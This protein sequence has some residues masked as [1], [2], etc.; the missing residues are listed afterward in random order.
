M[1]PTFHNVNLIIIIIIIIMII[2]KYKDLTIEIQ[3][4]WNLKTKVIPV[5]TGATGTISKSFRKYVSNIPGNHEVKE[6]QKTAILGT[7]HILRKML[8]E[9]YNGVNAGTSN[10]RTMNS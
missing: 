9:R 4:M 1:N 2:L 8:T 7:A 5:I 6:L 3:R 10:T